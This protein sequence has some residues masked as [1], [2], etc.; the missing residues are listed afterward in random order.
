MALTEQQ[1]EQYRR[2]GYA[3]GGRILDEVEL[4][5]LRAEMDR[6]IAGLPPGQRP[7]NMSSLHY[8][9]GYLCD[10]LLSKSLRIRPQLLKADD[11]PCSRTL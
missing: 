1:L 8:N 7:E 9:N 2:E 3:K 4:E 6:M 10:L 11:E 5:R